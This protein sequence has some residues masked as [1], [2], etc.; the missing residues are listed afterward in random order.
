MASETLADRPREKLERFGVV[1]LSDQEL[2]ALVLG[3][4]KC[5]RTAH[6]LAG[7]IL[8]HVGGAHRLSRALRDELRRVPGVGTAR[9]SQLLAAIELGRR[10]LQRSP[11]QGEIFVTPSDVAAFLAPRFGG[12][13]V[14][15]T[16]VLLLD[17]RHRLIGIRLLT[18]GT[19]DSSPLEP[20]DVFRVALAA[21]AAGVILFHNHPS[22]DPSPSPEDIAV[23]RRLQLAGEIMHV[24]LLDH[25]ILAERRYYSFKQHFGGRSPDA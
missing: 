25:L 12:R 20:R 9:A 21:G 18:V 22:G 13:D 10:T 2:V 3:H 19:L 16:G 4:G 23:T 17:T 6:E 11:D 8:T 15:H 7:D 1:A 24:E 5:G 14:E